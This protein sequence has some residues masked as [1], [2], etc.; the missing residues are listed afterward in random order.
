M[1]S[2]SNEPKLWQ[3]FLPIP[4]RDANKYHRGFVG[5]YAAPELTGATRLAASSCNR[6]GAGLVSVIAPVRGDVYRCCL[7][8]DIMVQSDRPAKVDVALGG[9]G[10]IA[11]QHLEELLASNNLKAR[12]FDADALPKQNQFQWLDE[13]CIL[14][15]HF[16]EFERV[17]GTIET[18]VEKAA[19]RAAEACGGIVVLKSA[20]TIIAS[21]D[22][23][24]V[25]NSHASPYLAKAGTGD[26]LAGLISGLVAQNMP[27]F[28]ACCAATWIHGEAAIRSGPGLIA[29][30]I[31][32]LI[33]D[34]LKDLLDV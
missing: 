13:H 24:T 9:S 5:I 25:C 1:M 19:Q 30:D 18:D 17:F 22:G 32:D 34:I 31:P 26:V 12:V 7:P 3:S 27:H 4:D 33:P 8:A 6:I 14:T 10:G 29:S 20:D 11:E 2:I 15:P 21:P 16:G 23:Q 28:H